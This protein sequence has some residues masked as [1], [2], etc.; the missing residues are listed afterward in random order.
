MTRIKKLRQK[1]KEVAISLGHIPAGKFT[2]YESDRANP[3]NV[4]THCAR[5]YASIIVWADGPGPA[6]WG[7]GV[8]N[9]CTGQ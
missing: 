6:I 9:I 5:C 7:G 4:Y 8:Q 1:A 3:K 2:R